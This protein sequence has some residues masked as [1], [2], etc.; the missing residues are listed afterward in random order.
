MLFMAIEPF[1]DTAQEHCYQSIA[2]ILDGKV[3][4]F[5]YSLF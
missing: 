4:L 3:Q 2:K 5:S 1:E